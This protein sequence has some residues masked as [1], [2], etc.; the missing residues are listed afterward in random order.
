MRFPNIE[1][2]T[3]AFFYP[4][5][6]RCGKYMIAGRRKK[7]MPCNQLRYPLEYKF[8]Q[9]AVSNELV[10]FELVHDEF[11]RLGLHLLMLQKA[12]AL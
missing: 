3:N 8:K 10:S 6:Q 2:S 12:K 9:S 5:P 11:S 7:G 1:K 4:G